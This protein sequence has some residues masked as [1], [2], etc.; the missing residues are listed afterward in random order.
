[1]TQVRQCAR[2]PLATRLYLPAPAHAPAAVLGA[3]PEQEQR[4]TAREHR[5]APTPVGVGDRFCAFNGAA[6][7]A[8]VCGELHPS[9][10][11]T[12]RGEARA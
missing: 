11:G 4:R 2:V 3:Q 8:G 12:R 7:S 6:G 10:V 9:T 1:M 5:P